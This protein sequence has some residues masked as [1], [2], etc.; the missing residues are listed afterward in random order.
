MGS[1]MKHLAWWF[2]S[3]LLSK[4]LNPAVAFSEKLNNIFHSGLLFLQEIHFILCSCGLEV[5]DQ[6]PTCTC[7]CDWDLYRITYLSS[8][9]PYWHDQELFYCPFSKIVLEL[10]I[11]S[12]KNMNVLML[13]WM[14]QE[15]I[16]HLW[17]LLLLL[18][19]V[20]ADWIKSLAIDFL[21]LY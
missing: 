8:N 10:W 20:N 4:I 17:L 18:P 19:V 9:Q 5:K 2:K 11:F 12:F 15:C 6:I 1:Q 21:F 16:T 13:Y 3:L 7:A 14:F